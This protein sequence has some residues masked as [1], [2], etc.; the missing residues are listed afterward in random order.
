[1]KD[2]CFILYITIPTDG[3]MCRMDNGSIA[4]ILVGAFRG[5]GIHVR[6][7]GNKGLMEN[8]RHGNKDRVRVWR[9]P[10]EKRKGEPVETVYLPDFPELGVELKTIPLDKLGHVR[11]STF[12]CG[13][14]LAACREEEWE[15][16]RVW[17]KLR[18]VLWVPVEGERKIAVPQRRVGQ[19]LLWSPDAED[20]AA[21]R[22]DWEE[23]AGVIGCGDV[24]SLTGH[25]GRYLQVRPKAAHGR[26]R[27]QGVDRE[28]ASFAVLP[29][30]FYLRA[31]FTGRILARHYVLPSGG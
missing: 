4:K 21:L 22:F 19:A 20:E 13:I 10:W 1:M 16:S 2:C 15:T 26:V 25:L 14:D 7:H 29:R 28:G 3:I 27:R 31:T 30:G 11:E 8:C 12:V 23:L 9:E 24:E 18:R 17:R 6:I 5:H